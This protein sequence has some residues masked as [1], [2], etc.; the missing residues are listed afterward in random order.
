MLVTS[1]GLQL[2]NFVAGI[3]VKVSAVIEIFAVEVYVKSAAAATDAAVVV[4]Y[5]FEKL[6]VAASVEMVDGKAAKAGVAVAA[7]DVAQVMTGHH[8]VAALFLL[9]P[10]YGEIA[11]VVDLALLTPNF[12]ERVV[13]V[14]A[15]QSHLS[16]LSAA[17][18]FLPIRWH[19]DLEIV[20]ILLLLICL[21]LGLGL[22]AEH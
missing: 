20:V 5:S 12:V 1:Q 9:M 11:S 14:V 3:G 10:N 15:L 18:G 16:V 22:E 2:A 7:A 17:A 8:A 4:I 13:V 19:V 21:G 6:E